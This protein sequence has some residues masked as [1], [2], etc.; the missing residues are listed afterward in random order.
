[1]IPSTIEREHVIE[2][3]RKINSEGVPAGRGSKKVG[4]KMHIRATSDI[5]P[6]TI[7][8]N[9]TYTIPQNNNTHRQPISATDTVIGNSR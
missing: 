3:I 1:M 2:A 5:C 8:N 9:T 4:M 6:Q 7:H